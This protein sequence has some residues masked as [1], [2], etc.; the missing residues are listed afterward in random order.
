M[1]RERERKIEVRGGKKREEKRREEKI[2]ED[3]RGR[4]VNVS[5][6]AAGYYYRKANDI[7]VED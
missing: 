2:G 5:G 1:K 6:D 4:D 7:I 3:R